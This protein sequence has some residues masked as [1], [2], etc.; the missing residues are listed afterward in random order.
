MTDGQTPGLLMRASDGAWRIL[1][2]LALV[3]VV[4]VVAISLSPVVVPVL[5]AVAVV[6][7][8]RPLFEL[9]ERRMPK[10]LAAALVLLLALGILTGA[11]WLI[12]ASI[13]ANWDALS[14]GVDD[15]V[16]VITDWVDDRVSR[17]TDEQVTTA[18]E[19]LT[20][21]ADTIVGVLAGGLTKG[22]ALIG[23]LLVGVFLSLVTLYFG[24]R[25]WDRFRAWTLSVMAPDLR[26]QVDLFFDRFAT[27][28]RNYWK[29]Q[30][31]I[32]VF[33][34]VVIGLGLWL[35]GVPLAFSIAILTFVVSFI[36]YLGAVVASSLAVFV[37]L[38]TGG[39]GDAGLALLLS[40]FVFNTGENL[41][42]PWMIR[43]TIKMPTFVAFITSI[44]GVLVAGALGAILAIPLVAL[45]GEARR[46]FFTD[47][48]P[49]PS[50]VRESSAA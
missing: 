16:I 31:L 22:V 19:N 17:L 27:V 50:G 35:I 3:A 41:V 7:V 36:P 21:L 44:V 47:G 11:G 20:D 4:A 28:L 23:T 40:L 13:V 38:G 37:A 43:E 6:P 2:V 34:A 18:A 9:L 15:A 26:P 46:I 8:G 30:A 25:D 33:D 14:T 39:A 49:D 29:A 12:V 10:S 48:D 5:L 42:R 24:L 1:V 32:G 45:A